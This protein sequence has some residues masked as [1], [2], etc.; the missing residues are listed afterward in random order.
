MKEMQ[1]QVIIVTGGTRGQGEAEVRL[2]V[3]EGAQV[4]FGGREEADGQRIADELGPQVRFRRQDVGVEAD[5]V[6]LVAYTETEFGKITGLVNNAGV[7]ISGA[8]TELDAEQVMAGLR[9]NQ[10]GQLLGM[11]HVV[12]ALRRQGGGSIVNIGSEAGLRGTPGAIAYSGSKA[13]I[14]AMTRSA[15]AELAGEGIRVNAVIPGIIDTPMIE[16]AA[17]AGAAAK[18]GSVVPLGRVGQPEEVAA[19]VVFLLSEKASFITGAELVVDGGR[20]V[21]PFGSYK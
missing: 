2:L 14:A 8:L 1:G 12:P 13:A 17:G 20:T 11:K 5:W 6:E 16:R 18:M 10:L 3:E 7:T 4:V 21:A 15:A 9:T 19:A